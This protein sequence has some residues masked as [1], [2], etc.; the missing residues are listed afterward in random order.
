MM[1]PS[2]FQ[3]T[4]LIF[5]YFPLQKSVTTP[6]FAIKTP[7]ISFKK[8]ITSVYLSFFFEQK[9]PPKFLLFKRLSQPPVKNVAR[10]YQISSRISQSKITTTTALSCCSVTWIEVVS[11]GPWQI[12]LVEKEVVR[13]APR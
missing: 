4:S 9:N 7:V 8:N 11:I 3:Y 13:K 5:Q 12:F 1:F 10:A 2:S 6:L